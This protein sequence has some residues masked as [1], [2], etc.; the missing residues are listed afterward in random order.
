LFVASYR[1]D[2]VTTSP[3]LRGALAESALP[4]LG[5]E[6]T[7]LTLASLSTSEAGLLLDSLLFAGGLSPSTRLHADLQ[8]VGGVPYLLVEL[9]AQAIARSGSPWA[10]V[11]DLI[12]QRTESCSHSAGRMLEVLCVAA[13]PL[14]LSL[15]ARAA[16]TGATLYQDA[17]S[18]CA[19]RLARMRDTQ[20][21]RCLEPYHDKVRY[22]VLARLSRARLLSVHASLIAAM[23]RLQTVEPESLL[24]HLLAV[25][26]TERAGAAA[27]EAAERAAGAFAWSRA[28]E[29]YAQAVQLLAERTPG[30]LFE[31]H[32]DALAFAGRHELSAAAYLKASE[33]F[34]Q[35][36]RSR[37]ERRAATQYLR[38]GRSREGVELVRKL[39]RDVG[40]SYPQR[41]LSLLSKFVSGRALQRV[42]D[43][44]PPRPR[45]RTQRS[46]ERLATLDAVYSELWFSDPVRGALIHVWYYGEARRAKD[47][48]FVRALLSEIVNQVMLRGPAARKRVAS[49]QR[50]LAHMQHAL[51]APY[52]RAI[53]LLAEAVALMHC[54]WRPRE[55]LPRLEQAEA[56][57][58]Q[59][60]HGAQF[61][62]AWLEATREAAWL[63][64]GD[65]APLVQAADL[66]W[67]KSQGSEHLAG[68]PLCRLLTSV[69]LALLIQ[70]R[71]DAA[72]R[73]LDQHRVKQGGPMNMTDYMAVVSASNVAIYQD[74]AEDA[75]R[76]LR[77]ELRWFGVLP[78]ARSRVASQDYAYRR[79]RDAAALYFH[80]RASS[81]AIEV[82][83][84]ALR[85]RALPPLGRG[86]FRLL[87]ASVAR[88]E[89]RVADARALLR[90]A[91]EELEMGQ[92]TQAGW[93]ARYRLAQL[94][95]S[96][97]QLA[98][99]HA[100]FQTR[101]VLC[102]ERWVSLCAPGRFD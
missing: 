49:L 59:Q 8:A 83:A 18:L 73:T 31:R 97:E 2:E 72:L 9:A 61:E 24:P 48:F 13:R 67:R 41:T 62:L 99:A 52:E 60:C 93:C 82:R 79:A 69:P 4:A 101:G 87:E 91:I 7:E 40:L 44:R 6:L 98:V 92:Q 58:T 10:D 34:G 85:A 21:E 88:A 81:L 43:V 89:G 1:E 74:R 27:L 96:S 78:I 45:P 95:H 68:Y 90:I 65:F 76:L 25:G 71:S 64:L 30:T 100:W 22:A 5:C 17:A 53:M 39:L 20:E 75:H 16:N 56:L 77:R 33:K 84:H 19:G 63:F 47:D 35:P 38:A 12:A 50:Q 36:D 94:E 51:S 86:H 32:G 14:P 29:L 3:F 102:P 54:E 46:R 66:R 23:E 42:V 37:V 70:D 57:L 26:D 11:S 15:A 28:A 80:R 55:A